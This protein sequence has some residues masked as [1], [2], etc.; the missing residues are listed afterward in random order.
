MATITQK[1]IVDEIIASD[2]RYMDDDLVVK[3]VEYENMFNGGL[4]WGII[5]HHEDLMRYHN[6]P[7]CHNPR[8]IWAHSS[9]VRR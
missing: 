6:S 2:G 4:A 5:Y 9:I 1:H 8:T 7:A 3:I